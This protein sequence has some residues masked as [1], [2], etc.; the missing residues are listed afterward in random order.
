MSYLTGA[1]LGPYTILER[2][3]GG[4]M[5]TVYKAYQPAMDR[6]VALKVVRVDIAAEPQFRERFNRE[7][8]TI[9][10]LEHRYILPV[11]DFGE[12]DGVPYLVMRYT[13]GGTL[14][15]VVGRG[16]LTPQRAIRYITQVAEAL[17][18]THAR[19]VIH[20]DIKP[21]NILLS[22]DDHVLLTDFGIAK[23]IASATAMTAT[24]MAL[25]T[26][27]YMAPEL[28][29][30]QPIDTYTDI[31]ALGI[32]L[33]ECLIGEP[34]FVAE[35]PWAVLNMQVRN[36]LPL[37]RVANPAIGEALEQAILKATNKD[38]ADRFESIEE[39]AAALNFVREG[40]RLV[41]AAP[42]PTPPG[43]SRTIL[44]PEAAQPMSPAAPRF[45]TPTPVAPAAA[46]PPGA[47]PLAAASPPAAEQGTAMPPAE[48]SAATPLTSTPPPAADSFAATPLTV[49]RPAAMRR[50][51]PIWAWGGLA[52]AVALIAVGLLTSQIFPTAS[53]PLFTYTFANGNADGWKRDPSAWSVVKDA[54]G[55]FVYQGRAPANHTVGTTP[56][57]SDTPAM[58]QLANYAVELRARVVKPGVPDDDSPDFFI[59]M[60]AHAEP[61]KRGGCESYQFYF[62]TSSDTVILARNGNAACT[63]T[64]LVRRSYPLEPNAWY[65]IRTEARG[66]H[67]KLSIDGKT[68]LEYDDPK[69]ERGFFYFVIGNDATVQFANIRVIPTG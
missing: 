24:G 9:A 20:R 52:I 36:P 25:G 66:A 38:P 10:R 41:G 17:A 35:T 67:L 34:P 69:M 3:G 33:Y 40:D 29:L 30:G 27:Y 51:I 6:F 26:P 62:D 22:P 53:P 4:G 61:A 47:A 5:A 50:R 43:T 63:W 57:D 31:Y 2:I 68:V 45:A 58:Q 7:A 39:F 56:I 19:N 59:S 46:D 49:A 13:D 11:Y 64:E 44:L 42:P 8:R 1:T 18:Y 16:P 65:V 60:R 55:A 21:E 54:D 28:V 15:D 32:V 23:M 12:A 14:H 37:P 48:P